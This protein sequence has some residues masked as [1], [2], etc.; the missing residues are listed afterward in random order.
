MS[1]EIKPLG[2]RNYGSIPHFSFSRLG[3]ADHYCEQGQEQIC[4]NGTNGAN[5]RYLVIVSIK[6]DGSNV[7]VCRKNGEIIAIGR[8]GYPAASSPFKMH[9]MFDRYVKNNIRKFEFLQEGERVVGEWLAQAHGTIY[10]LTEKDPFCVFDFFGADNKRA[11]YADVVKRCGH[12]SSPS[13][14]HI[15]HS[16][17]LSENGLKG[18]LTE[19]DLSPRYGELEPCEGAVYRVENKERVVFLCKY[20]RAGKQDGKYLKGEV[21]NWHD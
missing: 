11:L 17:G 10:N 5:K 2:V 6:M 14:L 21:W 20:V 15:G 8:A 4:F 19:Y 1:K 13:L 3:P 9:H 18:K 12:L 7:G 16:S